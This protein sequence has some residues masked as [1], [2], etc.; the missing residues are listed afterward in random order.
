M[1]VTT[2]I[3]K[4]LVTEKSTFGSTM[5][6][7]YV[8]EVDKRAD[9]GQIKRAIEEIYGVRVIYVATQVRKGYMKRNKMGWFR[10]GKHKRAVVK[11]HAEDRIELF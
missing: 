2:I 7:R 4:P 6:N 9:K 3:R 8:F 11:L 5:N 1:E 10:V